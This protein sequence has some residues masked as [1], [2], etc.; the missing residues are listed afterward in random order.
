MLVLVD[1]AHW[2]TGCSQPREGRLEGLHGAW[3][4]PIERCPGLAGLVRKGEVCIPFFLH[5]KL[6]NPVKCSHRRLRL[7]LRNPED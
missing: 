2:S 3:I 5:F 1:D 7:D 6:P 4:T